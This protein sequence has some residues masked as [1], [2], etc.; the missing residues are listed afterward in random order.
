[1]QF[2]SEKSLDDLRKS[3]PDVP[4]VSRKT[5]A[6]QL[7]ENEAHQEENF[8]ERY[9]MKRAVRTTLSED[10][11]TIIRQLEERE[12]SSYVSSVLDEDDD[13]P[14]VHEQLP[15]KRTS[16]KMTS[17]KSN[18]PVKTCPLV[19]YSESEDES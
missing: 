8:F 15:Q 18:P 4:Q 13:I 16:S 3:Q 5:L 6:E 17:P 11:V 7:A 9:S 19:E 2:V 10:D 12:T 1:M 14:L